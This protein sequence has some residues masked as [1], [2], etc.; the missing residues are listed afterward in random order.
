MNT[1]ENNQ[2]P[3]GSD[4]QKASYISIN[5]GSGAAL[6][7][8]QQ[9]EADR[10]D[11][12]PAFGAW[13]DRHWRRNST[14][15][16]P[17]RYS[18]VGA[19]HVAYSPCGAGRLCIFVDEFVPSVGR[20]PKTGKMVD[21]RS[22][23]IGR[24]PDGEPLFAGFSLDAWKFCREFSPDG[25]LTDYEWRKVLKGMEPLLRRDQDVAENEGVLI[26]ARNAQLGQSASAQMNPTAAL[27]AAIAKGVAQALAALNIKSDKG[28]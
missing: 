7:P 22:R 26:A 1:M 8:D 12:D 13:P 5:E 20:H 27:G 18:P 21:I 14:P 15:D 16:A 6:T 25:W 11:Y 17:Q 3:P 4:S 23:K 10:T 19:G 28:A 2:P 24:S 9:L